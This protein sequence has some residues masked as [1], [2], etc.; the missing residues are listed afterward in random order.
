MKD[1]AICCQTKQGSTSSIEDNRDDKTQQ[2]QYSLLYLQL[3]RVQ[4]ARIWH[5]KG[6]PSYIFTFTMTDIPLS[7]A[8]EMNLCVNSMPAP[9]VY[10]VLENQ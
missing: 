2:E 8:W 5:E 10:T 3:C 4:E 6:T 7:N 1:P 9:S